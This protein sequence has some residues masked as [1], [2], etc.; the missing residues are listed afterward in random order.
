MLS[1]S[2]CWSVQGLRLFWVSISAQ[3]YGTLHYYPC[4]VD[5]L[6]H[7]SSGGKEPGF[8]LPSV[9]LEESGISDC[10]DMGVPRGSIGGIQEMGVMAGGVGGVG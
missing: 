6:V 7:S 1:A 9:V 5:R 3:P 8:F 2:R 10:V 4:L